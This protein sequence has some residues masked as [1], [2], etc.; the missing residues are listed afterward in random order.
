MWGTRINH[1]F[2]LPQISFWL[3]STFASWNGFLIIFLLSC[4]CLAS[5][6]PLCWFFNSQILFF[7]VF[8][9][10]HQAVVVNIFSWDSNSK[11]N[12]LMKRNLVVAVCLWFCIA[13]S[14]CRRRSK[15]I[16]Q[17]IKPKT[18]KIYIIFSSYTVLML[19]RILSSSIIS[20]KKYPSNSTLQSLCTFLQATA[21]QIFN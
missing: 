4:K 6:C 9:G 19:R 13:S 12:L 2:Y 11:C 10:S 18:N 15:L 1:K 17:K 8:F 20:K 3:C 21:K 14:S 16:Q 5:L 7:F